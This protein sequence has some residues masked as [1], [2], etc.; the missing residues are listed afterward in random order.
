MARVTVED[1]I[2]HVD[3]RFELITLSS[4]RARELAS[5]AQPTIERRK[6]KNP[7]VALREIAEQ[8]IDMEKLRESVINMYQRIKPLEEQEEDLESILAADTAAGSA[9]IGYDA[10]RDQLIGGTIGGTGEQPVI[11]DDDQV[12]G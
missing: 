5:G 11:A 7:V 4:K 6:D 10:S 12:I 8:T 1:C 9:Q 2:E 3:S